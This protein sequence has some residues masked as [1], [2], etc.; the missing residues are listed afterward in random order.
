[1]LFTELSCLK[2][3]FVLDRGDSEHCV[4]CCTEI[5]C[6]VVHCEVADSQNA[7]ISS[8]SLQFDLV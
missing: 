5:H 4:R 3:V 2:E 7:F 6:T 1:M 8:I